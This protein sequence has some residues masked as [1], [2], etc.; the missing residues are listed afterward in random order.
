MGTATHISLNSILTIT[1]CPI[2]WIES[3]GFLGTRKWRGCR[4]R[5][6]TEIRITGQLVGQLSKSLCFRGRYRWDFSAS[7]APHSLS[8]A[9]VLTTWRPFERLGAS[10]P[11]VPR[12]TSTLSIWLLREEKVFFYLR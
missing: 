12:I 6:S 3:S 4:A 11:L 1:Q 5:A 8:E 10:N 2:I 7:A 9:T